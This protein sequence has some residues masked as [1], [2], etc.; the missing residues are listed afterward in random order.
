MKRIEN[1]LKRIKVT[2]EEETHESDKNSIPEVDTQGFQIQIEGD[3]ELFEDEKEK[4]IQGAKQLLELGRAEDMED[5][6][7]T[8]A[9]MFRGLKFHGTKNKENGIKVVNFGET[10]RRE[11]EI[12]T[13]HDEI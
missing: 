5:A 12:I 8:F 9:T 13:E 6:I 1:F 4:I 11:K 2:K 7:I 10:L 3:I